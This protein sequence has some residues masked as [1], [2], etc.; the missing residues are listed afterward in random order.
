MRG[1]IAGITNSSIWLCIGIRLIAISI[2]ILLGHLGSWLKRR[3]QDY[4]K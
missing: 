3:N 1:C 2:P 4:S